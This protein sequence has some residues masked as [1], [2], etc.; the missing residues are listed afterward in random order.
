MLL[1]PAPLPHARGRAETDAAGRRVPAD[2]ARRLINSCWV[3]VGRHPPARPRLFTALLFSRCIP[4]SRGQRGGWRGGEWEGGGLS[5]GFR[6][7]V[8]AQHL[9]NV[10]FAQSFPQRSGS[11]TRFPRHCGAARA[12]TAAPPPLPPTSPLFSSRSL[13]PPLPRPR[14][15]SPAAL[16]RRR[17]RPACGVAGGGCSGELQLGRRHRGFAVRR[18][19]YFSPPRPPPSFL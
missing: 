9:R 16:V 15:L 4:L 19:L 18:S 3:P 10:A 13:S 5:E 2:D 12:R 11:A 6:N 1:P 14:P 8:F 7:V 17:A